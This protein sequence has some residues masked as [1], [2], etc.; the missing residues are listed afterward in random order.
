[1]FNLSILQNNMVIW[2]YMS[3]IN[4]LIMKY[5]THVCFNYRISLT[6]IV[7]IS[8]VTHKSADEMEHALH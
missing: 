6:E 4:A 3:A 8:H 1:M 7:F 5:K 2:C